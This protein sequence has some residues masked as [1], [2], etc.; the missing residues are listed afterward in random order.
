MIKRFDIID[1]RM[2]GLQG[3]LSYFG[4]STSEKIKI[5]IQISGTIHQTGAIEFVV[6]SFSAELVFVYL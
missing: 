3:S 5:R 2:Q 6:M 1:Y 4:F